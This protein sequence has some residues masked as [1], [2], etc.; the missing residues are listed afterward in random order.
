[1]ASLNT[2]E[3]LKLEKIFDY[4]SGYVLN[5]SNRTFAEFFKENMNIEIYDDKYQQYGDSK[6]SRLRCFFAI[7]NDQTVGLCIFNLLEYYIT[8][9][10]I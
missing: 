5:F 3:K 9:K 1:M 10:Q 4:K 8:Q 2:T 6:G 7:E